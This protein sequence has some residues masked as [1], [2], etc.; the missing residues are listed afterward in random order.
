[1]K[2]P[3]LTFWV[4]TLPICLVAVGCRPAVPLTETPAV[5]TPAGLVPTGVPPTE[6]PPS[7]PPLE[8]TPTFAPEFAAE[9]PE[10]IAG[11]W[12]IKWVGLGSNVRFDAALTFRA[13]STFSMDDKTDGMHIFGG[14]LVFADGKVTLD[15]DECYD[16]VKGQFFH[17]TMTFTIFSTFQDDK[18]VLIRFVSAGGAGTFHKNVDG[19]TLRQMP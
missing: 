13:D 6:T 18:P 16:E 19:K 5:T 3:I 4:C 2:S 17:C 11:V 10:D 15:S 12:L 7:P 14:Q 9:K 8:P 1:M